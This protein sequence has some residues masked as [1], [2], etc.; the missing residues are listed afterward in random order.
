VPYRTGE[1]AERALA[2][3]VQVFALWHRFRAG[4]LDRVNLLVFMQ[5]LRD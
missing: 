2:V 4:Q 5:P 3:E 1:W